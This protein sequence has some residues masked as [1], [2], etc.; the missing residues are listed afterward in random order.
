MYNPWPQVIW[1]LIGLLTASGLV[2]L[3]FGYPFLFMLFATLAYL[4]W[5]LKNLSR[6]EHWLRSP[7]TSYEPP[8]GAGIWGEVFHR[9]YLMQQRNRARKRRLA[10]IISRF[11]E[12]TS[13]MTDAMLV[14]RENNEIEWF[15][16]A[17]TRLMGM[18]PGKDTG[19]RIDN[20]IRNPRFAAYLLTGDYEDGLE[21][22]SPI[23]E[24]MILFINIVPYGDTQRL[25]SA[26]DITRVHLL[27]Q[28]RRDFVANVSHELRTPLT[29]LN[30]YV[31][32]LR[33]EVDDEI[34]PWR[35]SLD[36]MHMQTQRM[37]RIVQDLLLLSRLESVQN[38][39]RH[40][41]VPVP[42][43]LAAL[44]EEAR[45][46]SG[47][48]QHQIDL[49]ADN[50]WL[51]GHA[52]ELTSV[53]SNLIFNAVQYTPE[54]GRIAIRWWVDAQGGHFQVSDTGIGIPE[55]HIPRLTERFYRVDSG[56]SRSEG[57]TGLGLAIV[58]YVLQRHQ[59]TLSIKST[60][61][62]G[63]EFTCHFPSVRVV[64]QL[65]QA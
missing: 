10:A 29:V 53:F 42:A 7:A 31:E 23:D 59:A 8:D 30:G 33:G 16:K 38:G 64:E 5:H 57:G 43:I 49:Q 1:T 24:E 41:P 61:G 25:L 13:A 27:E 15:N 17:A 65:R 52:D 55:R 46:L 34:S 51:Q 62:V 18:Q 39:Q 45:D 58:K 35:R 14:L 60:V 12:S 2:G 40:E 47:D 63:S 20:L 50:R 28:T 22:P 19:Q 26:R 44:A 11:Q 6:L 3:V 36:S 9:I 48:K 32:T 21:M 4:A 54:K 56:R 37:Q